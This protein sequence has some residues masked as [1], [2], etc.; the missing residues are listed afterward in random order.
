MNLKLTIRV[1]TNAVSFAFD[2]AFF[3]A[4]YPEFAC[5]QYNDMWVALLTS[6]VSGIA[7]NHNIIFDA[8][9]TPGS[10]NLAF[11]DRCVA[12]PTGCSGGVGGFNFCA[13]GPGDLAGT[14]FDTPDFE[15]GVNTSIG[16]GTGW[17]TTTAPVVP[18]EIMVIEFMVWDSS[19]G[20]YDS[21]AIFDY[22]RWQQASVATP[23]TVR[24]S[25]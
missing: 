17:M 24:A 8:A 15:C 9:G 23:S 5:T 4:E 25:P 7:N 19:D 21:A 6:K 11:F 18:G 16:G 2:H 14:G 22:F 12:G 10:V 13:G 20:I 3:S 1:P